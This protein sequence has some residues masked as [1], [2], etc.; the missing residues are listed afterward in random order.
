MI[1]TLHATEWCQILEVTNTDYDYEYRRI[2][3]KKKYYEHRN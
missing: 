3:K 1:I 2:K